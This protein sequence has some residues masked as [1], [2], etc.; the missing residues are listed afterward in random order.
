M[1]YMP[2][3][4]IMNLLK[5]YHRHQGENLDVSL[6]TMMSICGDIA[7]KTY[8]EEKI[9][10]SFGCDDSRKFADIRRDNLA[11]GIPKKLIKFFVD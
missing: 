6:C 10:I 11:V 3:G 9:N 1:S 4:E 5:I 7:V 2:P 8:L